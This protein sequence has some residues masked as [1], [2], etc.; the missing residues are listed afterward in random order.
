MSIE[1]GTFYLT[2]LNWYILNTPLYWYKIING[3]N[4]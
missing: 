4:P 1:L 3:I 2:I